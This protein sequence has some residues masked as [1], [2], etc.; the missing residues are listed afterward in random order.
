MTAQVTQVVAREGVPV[1]P[2]AR[3]LTSPDPSGS[4]QIRQNCGSGRRRRRFRPRRV[5]HSLSLRWVL[6]WSLRRDVRVALF[7]PACSPC[8]RDRVSLKSSLGPTTTSRGSRCQCEQLRGRLGWCC[9]PDLPHAVSLQG[10]PF[11]TGIAMTSGRRQSPQRYPV[12][13][14]RSSPKLSPRDLLV[15]RWAAVEGVCERMELE[16]VTLQNGQSAVVR[17][18]TSGRNRPGFLLRQRR[19]A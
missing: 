13:S 3:R 15:C 16:L 11:L 8:G 19:C 2:C 18:R 4:W 7:S 14:W 5:S 12:R 9:S 10:R 6:G 1:Q 17:K